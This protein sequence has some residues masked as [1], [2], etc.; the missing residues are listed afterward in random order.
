MPVEVVTVPIGHDNYAYVIVNG[1]DAIIIDAVSAPPLSGLLKERDL[2]LR[3]ILSTHHHGDHTGGNRSLK[4]ETGCSIVGGDRRISGIDRIVT[5]NERITEGP[6]GFTC[7]SVPG[8]TRGCINWYFHDNGLLFTGDTLFYCGCGRLF[9]GDARQMH[10]S[11]T[12]LASLPEST[13]VYCGHEY[14]LDNLGFARTIDPDNQELEKRIAYVKN[15]LQQGHP[16]GPSS[17]A[18]ETA[19]NPFLRTGSRAIRTAINLMSAPEET[20]FSALRKR[21]D[22]F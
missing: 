19:T 11:L 16:S 13:I 3:F 21:K 10:H 12:R 6:F 15:T 4:T 1:R 17:I 14:T 2:T 18:E 20:V 22:S 5:D 7:L 9:E 8:H